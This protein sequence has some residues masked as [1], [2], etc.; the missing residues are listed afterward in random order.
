MTDSA[1]A[2]VASP[3][4]NVLEGLLRL[5]TDVRPGEGAKALLLMVNVFMLL[6]CY[7]ILKPVREAL[8]L[9]GESAATKSYSSGAQ[10]LL[11]MVLVPAYSRLASRVPRIR[12]ITTVILFFASNLLLFYLLDLARLPHLGVAFFIWVGIFNVG[13]VAQFWSFANDLY[14]PEQGKRLFVIVAFGANLGAI[15]GG[16]IAERLIKPFGVDAL[17]LLAAG[18]LLA[19]LGLFHAI[20]RL[21]HREHRVAGAAGPAPDEIPMGTSGAF[22]LLMRDRYLLLIA[23][24][25]IAANFVN[26]NGEYLL[27][28]AVQ[29]AGTRLIDA[30]QTGGLSAHDFMKQFSGLFYASYQKWT[31]I[32]TALIQLFV[33]S[34][35]FKWF[36]IRMALFALPVIAMGGYGLIALLPVLSCVRL[37]KIAENATDYSLQK[38]TLQTLFLPTSREAKYKAKAAIDTVIVRFG[39]VLAAG[40]VFLA[41]Q[42]AAVRQNLA[43]IN[44]GLAGA[45]VVV[46]VAL[47]RRHQVL[48]RA[49]AVEAAP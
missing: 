14:T 4:P 28:A 5:F 31:S 39:D 43:W 1:E 32:V 21:D 6:T 19:C 27:S 16:V 23:V 24:L 8:I 34:R 42:Q 17:L 41:T 7:Y 26:S 2:S 48:E 40:L 10:A 20:N 35:V 44:I 9:S 49:R 45:W 15:L 37:V 12:L 3:R 11:L 46:V 25:V 29:S 18:L 30:G 38:T 47:G 22:E 13:I 33:V 36:G